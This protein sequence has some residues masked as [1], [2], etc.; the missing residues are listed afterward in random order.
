MYA[1]QLLV[2][3]DQLARSLDL[4]E[5]LVLYAVVSDHQKPEQEA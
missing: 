5:T 3:R 2:Q 4:R 1:C